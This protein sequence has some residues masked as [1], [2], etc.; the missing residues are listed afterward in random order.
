MAQE[1][2][3]NLKR[4]TISGFFWQFGQKVLSQGVGFIVSLVLARLLMPKD[5]GVVAMTSIFFSIANCLANSG[6]GTSLIQQKDNDELDYNTVFYTGLVLSLIMYLILFFTAPLIS[7]LYHNEQVCPVL[8]VIGISLLFT[9]INSVQNAA[10][11][12]NLDFKKFF[13]VGF[14]N[15]L[16]SGT[17][18]VFMALKGYGIWALVIP[19]LFSGAFSVILMNHL[20]GWKPKLQF[21]FARLRR[22][23]SFGLNLTLADL[24]GTIFN[25]AK[26]LVIGIKYKP[27][28]L[29]F[30]NRGESLPALVYGN[31]SYTMN[32]VLFPALSKLQ[33]SKEAVRNGIR[34]SIMLCSFIIAPC[35]FGIAACSK[36]IILILF[37]EKWL[38]AVPYMQALSFGYLFTILS[39]NN[40]EA[41]KAVGRTDITLKLEF[42]KK[43][44]WALIILLTIQISPLALA[45]G[46]TSYGIVSTIVNSFPNKRLIGYKLTHQLKDMYPPI[47]LSCIMGVIVYFINY[48][49]LSIYILLPLQIL[50]GA[51]IY[52][53][54]ACLFKLDS[55]TYA[56]NTM[57]AFVHKG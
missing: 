21:S 48:I 9:P 38:P 24:I 15:T 56:I 7:Q 5:F 25:E 29:A 1:N 34:R 40:L 44:I 8:R 6:L 39:T 22:L 16:V 49:P 14:A 10:V 27:S 46:N 28:D 41:I 30:Y 19:D 51:A 57:K 53:G 26:G 23:Y 20:I 35:V 36:N 12:R 31:I 33:D 3:D 17:I 4:K 32:G 11:S 2:F 54:L 47:L 42:F 13:Y 55:Y 37:S 52:I 18:G 50:A 45:I 43:P